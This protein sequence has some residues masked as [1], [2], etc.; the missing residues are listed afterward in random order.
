[1]NKEPLPK[2]PLYAADAAVLVAVIAIAYPNVVLME[3]MSFA[4]AAL[5]FLMSICAMAMV[6]L[7][8][9]FDYLKSKAELSQGAKEVKKDIDL[10]F[11]NLSALQLMEAETREM[12][13]KIEEKLA[14]QLAKDTEIKFSEF[15][16]GLDELRQIQLKNDES[17]QRAVALL[18]SQIQD[19]SAECAKSVDALNNQIKSLCASDSDSIDDKI[20]A[21]VEQKCE[22]MQ[23]ATDELC[24][25]LNKK[26]QDLEAKFGDLS[27]RMQNF[28]DAQEDGGDDLISKQMA[29]QILEDIGS[30]K[31]RLDEIEDSIEAL[32]DKAPRRESDDTEGADETGM[33]TAQTNEVEEPD[34][35]QTRPTG[36]DANFSPLS[37]GGDAEAIQPADEVAENSDAGE[38]DAQTREDTII[39]ES[40]GEMAE[41]EESADSRGDGLDAEGDS[42]HEENSEDGEDLDLSGL[43]DVSEKE[44]PNAKQAQNGN[45]A[46]DGEIKKLFGHVGYD[47]LSKALAQALDSEEKP[48]AEGKLGGLMSKAMSKAMS[49]ATAVGKIISDAAAKGGADDILEGLDFEEE[50]DGNSGGGQKKN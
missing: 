2:W 50:A 8:Y 23:N 26:Q 22:S 24:E 25:G 13:D 37:E 38:A 16:S 27:L 44:H 49:D 28:M 4:T 1:M 3:T 6:L 5:C 30:L 17:A 9:L 31:D 46:D 10:I 32:E 7:P 14:F 29:E 34:P 19:S 45:A 15:K 12:G 41:S 39:E 48:P 21:C 11:E 42:G 18:H 36:E 47:E 40:R 35:D 33:S 43:E 20:A